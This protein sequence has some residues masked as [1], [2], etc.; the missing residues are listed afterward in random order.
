MKISIIIP[1]YNS[2]NTIKQL[3][4]T[5]IKVLPQPLEIV[6]AN[7]GSKDS[8]DCVCCDIQKQHPDI[9]TYLEL[10]KNYGEHNAV[11]AAL[12]HSTGDYAV[13]MDDDF[14]NPPEEVLSLLDYAQK[15]DCDVVYASYPEKKHNWFRNMGSAL[16]GLMATVLLNK[17]KDLYLC[18]FKCLNRFLI[19]EITKYDGP[20]PYIDGLIFRVTDR[21][22]VVEVEH[23]ARQEGESG[24]TLAKLLRL[25]M[26]MFVNFSLLPLRFATMLGF[27]I[28]GFALLYT[29][30][31]TINKFFNSNI[32]A[33]WPTTVI[34]IAFFSG[35][36]LIMLG[37]VGEYV[38][39]IFLSQ[40]KTPQFCVR[41][42][43]KK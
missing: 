32:P 29:I 20:Y 7:D 23:S 26:N 43:H 35:A 33:G 37:L 42:K 2:E 17:P 18:S 21:Y 16:N 12:S 13:I 6:L 27:G 9:V 4:E 8:S 31:I 14:Q 28:S 39:R 24:Y 40:N 11:M 1:V 22:G 41:R 34:L 30:F 5:L 19:N 36:Q 15:N 10:S 25:W 3:V 38:G